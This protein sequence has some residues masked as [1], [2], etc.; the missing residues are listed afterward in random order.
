MKQLI[1]CVPN[2]SEGRNLDLIKQ[3]TDEIEKSEGVKLLDVDPGFTTNRT[4]V[5]FVG[6]PD[7]VV[8]TAYKVIA[9]AKELIDMRGHHGDH[10]RF[11]ATD[12]CPLVPVSNITME[13]TAEYARKLAKK[14]GEEL[15]IP[16][17]CY[18][19]AAFEPKRRNL[20]NCR[21]GEYEALKERIASAEW[22]P[23]FGPCEF[24]EEV[25]KSGASAI[26][27]RDFLIAVN[28]NLN[29]TSTRR[30]NAIAF[31]VREK[32]RPKREGN[33]ITGKI[34]KD[35][36][37]NPINIPGTL[38]G[39]KAI[40]WFIKEY[41]VAQVSMNITDTNTTPLHVAFEEVCN[42][43]AARGIRVTGTEIVGLVPKKTLIDAGKYFL[44]KQQRSLGI[45]EAE[46]I[47]IAIK[48]M[49]LDDL[50]P[51]IPEE[52]VI[53]Y[54]IEKD[55]KTEKL[56]D[57]TCTGFANETAS[58]SPAP[59]GGSIS[60]YMGSLGAALGTMVAN[61]SSHKPGWDERWEEFSVWAE[62]GQKIKDDLLWLVDEDTHSFNLI[63]EAF[64][65]PKGNDA[66][67]AARK[68]AIQDATKYAI[69]VP[70]KTIQ[71]S[72][73]VF[74][75]CAAM[76]EKGNPNSVTDAGVGVLC[77]RAA[78]MGA[79]LNV[80]INASSLEDKAFAEEMVSKAQAYVVK[81]KELETALMAKVEEVI[82]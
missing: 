2:F 58:E 36:N 24:T 10:P 66:E 11:G 55:N 16:V 25:A 50:K 60:A 7:E 9:K 35:E 1:E 48:S 39:T 34:M 4:V 69:E 15:N 31:D 79:Y 33:P 53:E 47:K 82:G 40:G 65:M 44:R 81:A 42:K 78:V 21:Q 14:V 52:K 17:F 70:Y 18:E 37:G 30:A 68:Q 38:K 75:L 56:M 5:T 26:G 54:L 43:A 64:G 71:R 29:T 27:A 32:G 46:I 74:E 49:G 59:G 23:D 77:A 67:K 80:K 12:V 6:T 19:N 63:M 28:Y 76:I 61:L 51:F 41:G 22:K 20:A 8:A 3:I 45:D 73:D 62:K 13:E 72:F 57:M